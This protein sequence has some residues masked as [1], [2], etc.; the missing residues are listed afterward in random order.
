MPASLDLATFIARWQAAT[1]SERSAA[2]QHFLDLC[3]VLDQPAPA[4]ADPA[5]ERY[6]FERSTK[7]VG[8]VAGRRRA[9][10]D[11]ARP[12]RQPGRWPPRWAG[13][14]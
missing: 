10:V 9:P 11:R 7:K 6:T 1:L 13:I 8:G 5:G 14:A 4:Q 2:H 3:A 12:S